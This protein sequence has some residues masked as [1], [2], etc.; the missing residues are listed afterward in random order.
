M[1]TLNP[2]EREYFAS[3]LDQ[4][5]KS[6]QAMIEQMER[7]N[8]GEAIVKRYKLMAAARSII[9]KDLRRVEIQ[10]VSG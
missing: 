4:E 3:F 10:E 8:T 2:Q 6:D 1:I 7:L 5:A 9:A